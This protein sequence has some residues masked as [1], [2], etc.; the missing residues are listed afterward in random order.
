MGKIIARLKRFREKDK[1][2]YIAFDKEGRLLLGESTLQ[3]GRK[4]S[5]PTQNSKSDKGEVNETN[6]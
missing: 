5:K 6:R 3:R 2:Y 1:L 4:P